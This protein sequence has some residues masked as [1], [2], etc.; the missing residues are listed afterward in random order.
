MGDRGS[1]SAGEAGGPDAGAFPG[2]IARQLSGLDLT[3]GERRSEPAPVPAADQAAGPEHLRPLLAAIEHL[4]DVTPDGHELIA[5]I[6]DEA[7]DASDLLWRS[8]EGRVHV[9][10]GLAADQTGHLRALRRAVRGEQGAAAEQDAAA[11]QGR[12][13]S[14]EARRRRHAS[15]EDRELLAAVDALSTLADRLTPSVRGAGCDTLAA[16]RAGIAA[17]QAT[18]AQRVERAD[19]PTPPSHPGAGAGPASSR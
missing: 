8:R 1:D 9:L 17:V 7:H 12:P 16:L 14:L 3:L 10:F 6:Y 15:V 5:A 4:A 13:P 18:V 11:E 19:A 2:P